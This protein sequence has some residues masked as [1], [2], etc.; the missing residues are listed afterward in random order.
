MEGDEQN[1]IEETEADIRDDKDIASE[2]A[3]GVKF[4]IDLAED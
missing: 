2:A 4:D 3:K 1:R